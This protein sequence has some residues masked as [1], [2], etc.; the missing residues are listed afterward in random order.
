MTCK[1]AWND[2][3]LDLNFTKAFRTGPYKKHRETVLFEREMSILPTRQGRVEST[4]KYRDVKK[5]QANLNKEIYELDKKR[6]E[7]MLQHD[8]LM[9]RVT[10]YQYESQGREPPAWTLDRGEERTVVERAKFIM[11][12]PDSECRGF[13]SS[14]Y[15]CGTCQKWAC[16]DCLEIKGD[17]KD[18]EHTCSEERKESVKMI[19]KE[20]KP[21]PKCGERISKIDGCDQMFCTGCHTAFSWNT[22][23]IVNGV[24]HNPHYYEYLR[25]QGGGV[26]PRNPGDVPCGGIP[27]FNILHNA[28]SKCSHNQR[29]I[30]SHIHRITSEIQDQRIR[31]YQ[32]G[33]TAED[34]GDL[35][36][37]YLM[38][39]IDKE[40]MKKELAKREIK[41]NKHSAIRAVLEMLVTTSSMML[42]TIVTNPP[43]SPSDI[44]P[45]V[46]E[47]EN[48]KEYVNESL[49]RVSKMKNCS[50]PLIGKSS[51]G[52]WVWSPKNKYDT[53]KKVKKVKKEHVSVAAGGG[54]M[55][56][57]DDNTT[58]TNEDD[59][60]DSL[61]DDIIANTQ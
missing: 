46:I 13:L 15:K 45:V 29:H 44:E 48:L 50:V 4:I 24:I 41:R 38:K 6:R 58:N 42:N 43:K 22:G 18:T 9:V 23:Q 34:N 33:F 57:T 1:R 3:F 8:R 51:A 49:M 55:E 27:Y 20:S 28:M 25:K 59:D 39:Q 35:G 30:V 36:V 53:P 14:A 60:D 47:F 54:G 52:N 37:L 7:L 61:I 31:N 12:C 11:K 56:V 5:E 19:L 26:A 2:E 40:D 10:R 17:E 21:C 32:G 16:P